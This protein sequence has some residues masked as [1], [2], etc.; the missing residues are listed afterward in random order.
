MSSPLGDCFSRRT[1]EQYI[2]F[3]LTSFQHK[4]VAFAVRTNVAYDGS[5]EDDSPV[6]GCYV[7]FS[8]K[9]FL[10]I[11]EVRIQ[12]IKNSVAGICLSQV[13]CKLQRAAVSYYV[14]IRKIGQLKLSLTFLDSY[15]FGT[16][17]EQRLSKTVIL[18]FQ[19]ILSWHQLKCIGIPFIFCQKYNNDWWIGRLVK[20]GCEVGFIPSP[21]K[22]EKLQ[23]SVAN[24]NVNASYSV[25]Q[26]TPGTYLYNYVTCS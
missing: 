4:T 19:V 16:L 24:N 9:D 2:R 1:W 12:L 10:H 23:K 26:P 15:M 18:Y 8:V 7:S 25:P 22:F 5:V 3:W 14:Q 20:E 21:V 13:C 17:F 6:K 11:K